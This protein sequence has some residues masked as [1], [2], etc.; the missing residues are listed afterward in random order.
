MEAVI[1]K[2]LLEEAG[3]ELDAEKAQEFLKHA[4]E[5]LKERVGVATLVTMNDAQLAKMQELTQ[6]GDDVATKAWLDENVA[7]MGEIIE[8]EIDILLDDI[9]KNNGVI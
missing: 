8:D 7:D 1:T 3:F 5:V 2:E 9:V 6:A 4:N